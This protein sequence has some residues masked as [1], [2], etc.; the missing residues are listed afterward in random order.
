MRKFLCWGRVKKKSRGAHRRVAAPRE[1]RGRREKLFGGFFRRGL[2]RSFGGFLFNEVRHRTGLDDYKASDLT[3]D[4]I[5][6][7]RGREFAWEGLRRQDMIRF[8]KWSEAR[9][10]KPAVSPAYTKLYPIPANIRKTNTN[11]KQ[12]DG[13]TD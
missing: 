9:D 1:N 8:G 7:E 3:L 13:Y 10:L 12:N 11:L 4:E 6:D 2:G 5:Y